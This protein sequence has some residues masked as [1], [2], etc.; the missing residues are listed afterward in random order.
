MTH[1]STQAFIAS[2]WLPVGMQVPDRPANLRQMTRRLVSSGCN[3]CEPFFPHLNYSVSFYRHK[4]IVQFVLHPSFC[5]GTNGRER[6]KHWRF[7]EHLNVLC[8]YVPIFWK[9][10]YQ[11]SRW[12]LSL[13]EMW[14]IG[15]E[16]TLAE[17][18]VFIFQP[19]KDSIKCSK[20]ITNR[21]G[22]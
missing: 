5:T 12:T 14:G 18:W 4:K 9:G 20:K 11:G 10:V 8:Q 16:L 3:I 19:E 2:D 6:I 22:F 13:C 17:I 21:T 7:S 1:Q 15:T